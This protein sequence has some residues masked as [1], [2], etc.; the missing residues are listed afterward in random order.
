MSEQEKKHKYVKKVEDGF[1]MVKYGTRDYRKKVRKVFIDYEGSEECVTIKKLSL[2]EKGNLLDSYAKISAK[3]VGKNIVTDMDVKIG[4]IGTKT[5]TA[6]LYSA[7]FPVEEKFIGEVL[8]GELAEELVEQCDDFNNLTEKK[9]K[10]SEVPT[11]P[12]Q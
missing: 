11:N 2:S 5:L 9:E 8:D 3:Q 6:N 7:P 1:I 12:E 10:T 4:V